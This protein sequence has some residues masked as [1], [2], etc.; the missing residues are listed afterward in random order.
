MKNDGKPRKFI[1]QTFW[2]QQE[3]NYMLKSLPVAVYSLYSCHFVK[4]AQFETPILNKI[5]YLGVHGGKLGAPI[6]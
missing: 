6:P 5:Y 4:N 1:N 2:K 3:I